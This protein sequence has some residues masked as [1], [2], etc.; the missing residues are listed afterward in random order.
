MNHS[1]LISQ[2]PLSSPKSIISPHSF[3]F[4][5]SVCAPVH[6]SACVL[7]RAC[8]SSELSTRQPRQLKFLPQLKSA[9]KQQQEKQQQ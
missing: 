5:Q 1:N 6:Q 2:S 9:C 4:P 8:A 7:L 3:P